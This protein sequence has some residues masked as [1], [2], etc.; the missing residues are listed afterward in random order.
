MSDKPH[1]F[2]AQAA[3]QNRTDRVRNAAPRL[4]AALEMVWAERLAP[5][6][7]P[8]DFE[9]GIG[10]PTCCVCVARAA[11]ETAHEHEP[12]TK[13]STAAAARKL[14]RCEQLLAAIPGVTLRNVTRDYWS[15]AATVR[16]TASED[17]LMRVLLAALAANVP[18]GVYRGHNG[19]VYVVSLREQPGWEGVFEQVLQ[20]VDIRE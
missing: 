7:C 3:C 9:D 11:L 15:A 17:G 8:H 14:R 18:V 10:E 1:P 4:L 19:P 16:F 6:S 2:T 12:I 5:D 20:R 13:P